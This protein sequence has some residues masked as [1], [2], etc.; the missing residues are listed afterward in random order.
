M[1]VGTPHHLLELIEDQN[2]S[3]GQQHLLQMIAVIE[4]PDEQIFDQEAAQEGERYPERKRKE[5]IA[6]RTREAQR[7]IGAEHVERAV[8]EVDHAQNAEN[9]GQSACGQEDQQSRLQTVEKLNE[10][11][12]H[13][14]PPLSCTMER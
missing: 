2:Q 4:M 10:D 1:R 8:R 12:A 14:P 13:D 9:K 6:E 7:Q 3:E 5:H 11:Q